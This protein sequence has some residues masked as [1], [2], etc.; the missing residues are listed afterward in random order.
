M[1]FAVDFQPEN[2]PACLALSPLKFPVCT[3]CKIR[4]TSHKGLKMKTADFNYKKDKKTDIDRNC[5]FLYSLHFILKQSISHTL[6]KVF[7]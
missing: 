1:T 7:K 5:F 6:P 4:Q 3:V 2:S